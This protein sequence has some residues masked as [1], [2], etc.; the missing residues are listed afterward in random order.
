[1][2]LVELDHCIFDAQLLAQSH[3]YESLDPIAREAFVNHLHL[4]G[5][6]RVAAADEIIRLWTSE[7]QSRWPDRVFR[8]YRHSEAEEI[9]I[10]FHMIRP[11][12]PNW[13]DEGVEILV[14]GSIADHG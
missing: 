8:I 3:G 12:L 9:T 10:R 1:M 14:V 7:M 6:S 5:E 4:T 13:C 2:L 11:E